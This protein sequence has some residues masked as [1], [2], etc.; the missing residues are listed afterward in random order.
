MQL[1]GMHF[2]HYLYHKQDA[3]AVDES[4]EHV[5]GVKYVRLVAYAACTL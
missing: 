2:A 3:H 4:E 1:H 5:T